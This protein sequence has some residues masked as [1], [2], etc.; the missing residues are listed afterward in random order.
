[1]NRNDLR[2]EYFE[3]LSALVTVNEPVSFNK[4]LMQ[5]HSTDFRWSV[6]ND[7]NR[8]KEGVYLRYRFAVSEHYDEPSELITDC[9][10]GP[11]SVLEMMVA[12]A[13]HCEEIM[14]DPS[15]GNRTGQWFWNMIVSL[16]LGRMSDDRYD[17]RVVTDVIERFLDR[18]YEPNGKGGLF[19][20][21]RCDLDLRDVE[22]WFQT[23]R[24]L[25][26]IT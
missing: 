15:I 14:E 13:I 3:W 1:M 22:I 20:I 16:G 23:C 9:L 24:Y 19:T 25:D 8:A 7:Q 6:P 17:K 4:L 26:T 10:D 2:N 18:D 21:R 11:C 5:L 12:L